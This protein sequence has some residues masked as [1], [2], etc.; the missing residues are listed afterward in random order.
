MHAG[1]RRLAAAGLADQAERLAASAPRGRR[2]RRR[3]PGRPPCWKMIPCLIGKC[4]TAP[5]TLSSTS[6]DWVLTSRPAWST[7]GC[8]VTTC[9]R[10]ETGWYA[11]R[12]RPSSPPCR[13]LLAAVAFLAAAFLAAGLLGAPPSSPARRS[14][15]PQHRA[16]AAGPAEPAGRC[17]RARHGVEADE[18]GCE[19]APAVGIGITS[20]ATTSA[21]TS[22]AE[23]SGTSSSSMT[24]ELSAASAPRR[25]S[26]TCSRLASTC[27]PRPTSS[28]GSQQADR[29]SALPATCRSGGMSVTHWS[30]T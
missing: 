3:A 27:S 16:V 2:R 20:S 18:S 10:S 7:A 12:G 6:P 15:S 21:G 1:E 4:L 8:A 25:A 5:S 14:P 26:A 9:S 22:A 23:P 19:P 13:W 29:W 24:S 28:T 30:M 11:G 17:G